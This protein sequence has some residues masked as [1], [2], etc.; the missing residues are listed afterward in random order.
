MVSRRNF[1]K[2]ST[3]ATASMVAGVGKGEA[4][5]LFEK[6][7]KTAPEAQ[8]VKLACIGI[9]NRGEQ[10]IKQF[11]KTRLVEIT[12]LCDVDLD[13]KQC[14]WALESFP[15]ARRFNDWRELFDKFGNGFEAVC[16]STP[17][18]SH[19][20]IAM[21]ALSQGDHMLAFERNGLVFVFRPPGSVRTLLHR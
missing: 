7:G 15:K 12:A 4:K 6:I 3:L 19:F 18:H 17:D 13:G 11:V 8:K 9:G 2:A 20:A 10:N 1:I 5:S 14:K 21:L 16:V